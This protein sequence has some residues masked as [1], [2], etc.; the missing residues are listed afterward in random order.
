MYSLTK[1]IGTIILFFGIVVLMSCYGNIDLSIWETIVLGI[2]GLFISL[3]GVVIWL[4][5]EPIDDEE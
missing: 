3:I 1:F 5:C 4:W 2:M